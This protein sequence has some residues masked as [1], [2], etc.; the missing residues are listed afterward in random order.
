MLES[1]GD[2]FLNKVIFV[3]KAPAEM[4]GF[5]YKKRHSN[6]LIHAFTKSLEHG[7]YER[8]C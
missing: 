3:F 4:Q 7:S 6:E 2:L 5:F 1:I 8:H